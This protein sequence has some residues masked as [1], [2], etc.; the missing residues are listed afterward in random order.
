MKAAVVNQ[1]NQPLS[2]EEIERPSPARDEV[3]IKVEACGVCHSD[4][5]IAEGDWTQLLK[6]IKKPLVP[7][8][9]VVGRV[10]EKGEV[11]DNLALGDRVGVACAALEAASAICAKKAG[12]T[13][14]QA[15][16]HGRNWR[17]RVRRY[18]KAKPS[19]AAR[20]PDSLSSQE[21][22]RFFARAS[23][24]IAQS[25]QR[26]SNPASASRYSA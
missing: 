5:H 12:R 20:V 1:F 13:C 16:N 21:A 2:I 6:I 18:I 26:T 23:Q 15:G 8:H 25:N 17:W 7:G 22:A 24:S 19:H 11:F 10:V 9:E 4:L 3:L 14:R